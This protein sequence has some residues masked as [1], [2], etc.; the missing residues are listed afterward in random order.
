M[1]DE[2][3]TI[4]T[5]ELMGLAVA[6]TGVVVGAIVVVGVL[7]YC[8]MSLV[9]FFC[10]MLVCLVQLIEFEGDVLML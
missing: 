6:V 8:R 4:A 3:W 2:L 5:G 7:S 1:T 9:L 10:L